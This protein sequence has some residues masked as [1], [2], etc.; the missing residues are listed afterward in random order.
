MDTI[1]INDK[2]ILETKQQ[3][4]SYAMLYFGIERYKL[5]HGSMEFDL[6]NLAC[7]IG[8]LWE[9]K[10]WI[11]EIIINGDMCSETISCKVSEYIKENK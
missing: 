1:I 10:G 5:N 11:E 4:I 3:V 8:E 2:D 6:Y 7:E 9:N